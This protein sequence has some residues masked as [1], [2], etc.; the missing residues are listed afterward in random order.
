MAAMVKKWNREGYRMEYIDIKRKIYIEIS[1]YIDVK[2]RYGRN[3]NVFII[4]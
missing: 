2:F 1:L 3:V 4:F